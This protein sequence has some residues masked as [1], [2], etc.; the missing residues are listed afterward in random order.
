MLFAVLAAL[1]VATRRIDW[2]GLFARMRAESSAS[3]AQ[4]TAGGTPRAPV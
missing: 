2:Y 4:A 1:M 3:P